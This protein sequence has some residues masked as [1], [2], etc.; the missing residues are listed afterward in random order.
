M[1]VDT[2]RT[3]AHPAVRLLWVSESPTA[4]T[5]YGTVTRE[6]LTRFARLP[7]FEVAAVA[8]NYSGWPYDRKWIPFDLYPSSSFG[9]DTLEKAILHFRPNVV[10]GFG[11]PWMIEHLADFRLPP[12]CK[13]VLYFPLDGEPFP[14]PWRRLMETADAAVC[15]SHFGAEQVRAACPAANVAMIYHGVDR[16]VFRPLGPKAEAKKRQRLDGRFVV[17]CVARNQPRKNLPA[18]LQ[19]FSVFAARH[20][21]TMLYLHTNPHDVGWDL[22][23]LTRRYGIGERTCFSRH[24]TIAHGLD[25]HT[26]NE[27]YN[28]FDIMVLPSFGEGFG[29]PL[30][31]A[32]AAGT[33][34]VTTDFS[35]AA[36][37]VRG[38]GELIA[39]RTRLIVGRNIEQ[40]V[41]DVDD[42]VACMDRLYDDAQL[43]ERHRRA[44]L[45]FARELDWKNIVPQWH[46]L[47][48][49]LAES[50]GA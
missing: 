35:A 23:E 17:G 30:L 8:S 5:G 3:A 29:L 18:L 25:G 14:S 34:C 24:A 43:R 37:L 41:A 10:A 2:A 48:A 33:P 49:S 16:K 6:L 32:M 50:R 42:M 20:D 39:V 44:G 36:E 12:S 15:C 22:I 13:L 1:N 40:A 38:R 27:I 46:Q 28:L 4:L 45:A 7:G 47:L 9:R 11:D 21:D 19:A 31:E 26:L